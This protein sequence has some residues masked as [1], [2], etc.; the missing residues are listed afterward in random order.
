MPPYFPLL[1]DCLGPGGSPGSQIWGHQSYVVSYRFNGNDKNLFYLY[2]SL[3]SAQ[4]NQITE[5][6]GSHWNVS[7]DS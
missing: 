3:L 1:P 5:I 4:Y 2:V 6:S 7:S